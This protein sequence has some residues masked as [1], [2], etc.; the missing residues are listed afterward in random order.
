MIFAPPSRVN[1]KNR[2]T[3][4]S[5]LLRQITLLITIFERLPV[6]RL[7]TV[8]EQTS[9]LLESQKEALAECSS[10]FE[11]L[12]QSLKAR[13]GEFPMGSADAEALERIAVLVEAQAARISEDA[14][15]DIEFLTEQLDALTKVAALNNPAQAQALLAMI[16]DED[17]E[18]TDTET[19]KE[20]VTAES[21]SSKQ[22][23]LAM[24]NDIKDAINEGSAEEV[25]EYLESILAIEEDENLEENEACC[26]D[27]ECADEECG[28][29]EEGACCSGGGCGSDEDGDEAGCGSGCGSNGRGCG[30]SEKGT[31]IFGNLKDYEASMLDKTDDKTQH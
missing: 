12:L 10:M 24:I 14:T 30:S 25:A 15:I 28:D 23:L 19:F 13:V 3:Y 20:E 29:S 6:S 31:D 26:D 17:T 4:Y 9:F 5:S 22:S 18:V 8:I 7:Q 1:L 21:E 11:G 16:I 27:E 2:Y